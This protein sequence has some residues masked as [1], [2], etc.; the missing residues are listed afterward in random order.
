MSFTPRYTD[1]T[2][3]ELSTYWRA[4]SGECV[5]YTIGR[6]REI[7]NTPLTDPNLAWPVTLNVIQYAKQIYPNADEANGWIKD[8]TTPSLGAIACWTGNAGHCMNVE[9]IN[10]NNITMS[11]YN[12]PTSTH[13][14][15]FNV[16]TFSI[17]D[18]TSGISG[19]GAF[20]GFV[21]N[22][23]VSPGPGPDPPTPT[24]T[25]DNIEII[26]DCYLGKKKKLMKIKIE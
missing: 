12:F 1:P 24:P 9:A 20:Q 7:A 23:Y 22:P 26:L 16:Q 21:R 2:E 3:P 14:H 8:G 25:D 15:R 18:I 6:I 4:F 10:G 17:S 11:E 5:W 13:H 19:L